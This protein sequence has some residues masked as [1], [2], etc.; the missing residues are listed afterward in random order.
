MPARPLDVVIG[1]K[2]VAAMLGVSR[3]TVHAWERDGIIPAQVT[4]QGWPLSWAQRWAAVGLGENAKRMRR[5]RQGETPVD[6][7]GDAAPDA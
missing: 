2:A 1:P 6:R 3:Q 4:V 5:A 7:R